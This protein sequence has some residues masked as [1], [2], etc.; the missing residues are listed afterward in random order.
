MERVSQYAEN[1]R[2]A[3]PATIVIQPGEIVTLSTLVVPDER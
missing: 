1:A 3:V 2:E